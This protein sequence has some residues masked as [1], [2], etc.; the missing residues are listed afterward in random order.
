MRVVIDDDQ[1]MRRAF[2]AWFRAAGEFGDIPSG[3]DSQV[4]WHNGK[5]YVVLRNVRGVLKVYRV[6]LDGMLKGLHRYPPAIEDEAG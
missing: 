4:E 2:G 3:S 1:L 5:Q 6:R